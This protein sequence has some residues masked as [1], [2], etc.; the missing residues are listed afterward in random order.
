[1]LCTRTAPQQGSIIA[2]CLVHQGH[3]LVSAVSNNSIIVW[4]TTD[5]RGG[6]LRALCRIRSPPIGH[7]LS[8]ATT[9]EGEEGG[10]RL[11]LGSQDANVRVVDVDLGSDALDAQRRAGSNELPPSSSASRTPATFQGNKGPATNGVT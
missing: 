4:D 2:L 1:M 7:V 3:R 5:T 9:G 8:L 10:E 6:G 11:L